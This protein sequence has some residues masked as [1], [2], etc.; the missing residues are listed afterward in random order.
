MKVKTFDKKVTRVETSYQLTL[1][2]KE[3]CWL[4]DALQGEEVDGQGATNFYSELNRVTRKVNE[5]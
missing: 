2:T 4:D 3:I 1:S 5:R